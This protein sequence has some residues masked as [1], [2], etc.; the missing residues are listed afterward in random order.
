VTGKYADI[1]GVWIDPVIAQLMMTLPVFT[2]ETLDC[3]VHKRG[4][5]DPS[6]SARR[7]SQGYPPPTV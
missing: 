3:N 2:L 6:S 5:T 1:D 7:C 4:G